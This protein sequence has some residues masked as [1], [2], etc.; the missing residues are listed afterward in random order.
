MAITFIE[1]GGDAT[2]TVT[3]TNGTWPTLLGTV[4][5]V[6]SDFVHS[7]HTRSLKPGINAQSQLLTETGTIS[8]AGARISL[9][10]YINV[11]PNATAQIFHLRSSSG[12][13]TN[14]L[15]ITSAGVLQLWKGTSTSQ[16]GSDGATLSTGAWYR[17]SLA[18]TI[19]SASVNR[20]ELYVNGASSIS[21]T[22]AASTV[23][24]SRP[25]F[26]NVA[27]DTTF[28][29]RI[30]DVYVDND[31][32]LTDPGDVYVTAKLPFANGTASDFTTAVGGTTGS[33]YGTGHAPNVNERALNTS[34]A[35]AVTTSGVAASSETF[36]IEPA[37]TG[38]FD[39]SSV[40]ILG[41]LGW[42]SAKSLANMTAMLVLNGVSFSTNLTSTIAVARKI[43]GSNTYPSGGDAIGLTTD[44]ITAT[45]VTLYEAGIM[46]AYKAASSGSAKF[47]PEALG[48][49]S[50][51][52]L[53]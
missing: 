37:A 41:V 15:M 14:S 28:D 1:P 34:H 45:T 19:T 3:T 2:Y 32:T 40:T 52:G 33:G 7:T 27:A 17:L 8:D 18:Y 9:R 44:A 49:A 42:V 13:V 20:F 31:N 51:G 50:L 36:S 10:V 39:L 25:A 6:A 5:T 12:A 29:W 21:A 43:S 16:I 23:G 24:T 38:D 35:Y 46:I 30:S 48:L 53:H 26:G 47:L 22:N 11:L 4:P